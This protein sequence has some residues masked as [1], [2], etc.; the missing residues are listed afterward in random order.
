MFQLVFNWLRSERNGTGTT[1]GCVAIGAAVF[2]RTGQSLIQKSDEILLPLL[3]KIA[4]I[5]CVN[6]GSGA[7]FRV[8]CLGG[9]GRVG[10]RDFLGYFR[11]GGRRY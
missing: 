8:L 4:R 10:C 6:I 5:V 11:C 2:V 1:T 9:N 3:L 7:G